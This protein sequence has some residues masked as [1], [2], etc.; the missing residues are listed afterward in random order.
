ML[1]RKSAQI[2]GLQ[3]DLAKVSKAHNDLIRVRQWLLTGKCDAYTATLFNSQHRELWHFLAAV[4]LLV[5]VPNL[6]RDASK[7]L[8]QW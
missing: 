2:R 8:L 5:P 1:E 3:Y 7:M 6:V 4:R